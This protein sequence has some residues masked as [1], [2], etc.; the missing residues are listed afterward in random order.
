M[1]AL[2]L[3]NAIIYLLIIVE[4]S[5]VVYILGLIITIIFAMVQLIF[6]YINKNMLFA[7]A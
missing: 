5:K 7:L 3:Q 4:H 1:I 2:I 6:I